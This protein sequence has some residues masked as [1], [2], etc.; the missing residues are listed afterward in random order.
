MVG[1]RFHLVQIGLIG[2]I[3]DLSVAPAGE[4]RRSRHRQGRRGLPVHIVVVLQGFCRGNA[5]L[6][7][8]LDR[9]QPSRHVIQPGLRLAVLVFLDGHAQGVAT[10]AGVL[11]RAIGVG[12]LAPAGVEP[13]EIDFPGMK[14]DLPHGTQFLR[15]VGIAEEDLAVLLKLSLLHAHDRLLRPP[16]HGQRQRCNATVGQRCAGVGHADKVDVG[17]G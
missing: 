10:G 1:I 2:C 12:R 9:A 5:L 8:H 6:L 13:E 4:R 14:K 11:G 17:A 16:I 15:C 7:V 3:L